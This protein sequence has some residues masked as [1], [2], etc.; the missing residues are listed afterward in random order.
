MFARTRPL[1]FLRVVLVIKCG[2][3][4]GDVEL[5]QILRVWRVRV[6]YSA[7][8]CRGRGSCFCTGTGQRLHV[9]IKCNGIGMRVSVED[10]MT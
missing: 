1:I 5:M 8:P 7:G 10:L 3:C 9:P 6:G 4:F 2:G